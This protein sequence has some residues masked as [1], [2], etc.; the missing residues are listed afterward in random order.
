MAF[1]KRTK[2]NMEHARNL[3]ETFNTK[4]AND[5]KPIRFKFDGEQGLRDLLLQ[6]LNSMYYVEKMLIK[7]F[8]KMIKHACNFELIEAIT[9]HLEATKKQIIRIEDT[10]LTLEEPAI[11][12]RSEAIESMLQEIDDIIE[13]T[14]FGMVRDAG[15]ILA[16]H[17]IEHYEIATYSI[18]STFAENLKA[19]NIKVLMDESLNEE[20]VAEMRLA[21]IAQTIQFYEDETP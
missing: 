12:N 7:S 18:L 14:K 20:K 21:K 1:N 3:N 17:K 19:E 2:I 8:P 11:L 13:V 16:L 15:I 9:I 4:N 5:V 6:E 10:F